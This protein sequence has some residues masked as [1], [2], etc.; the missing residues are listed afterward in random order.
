[1]SAAISSLTAAPPST[2]SAPPDLGDR[3]H[4]NGAEHGVIVFEELAEQFP[5]STA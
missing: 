4:A 1:M 3:R 5:H 2:V